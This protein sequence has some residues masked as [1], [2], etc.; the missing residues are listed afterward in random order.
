LNVKRVLTPAEGNPLYPLVAD[1]ETLTTDGRRQARVNACRQWMLPISAYPYNSIE[2]KAEARVASLRFFDLWYL[3]P[4]PEIEFDPMFYDDEPMR[5]PDLHWDIVRQWATSDANIAIAPRGSAKS[6]LVKK[7][8]ALLLLSRPV[9]SITY[10]T[11]TNENATNMGLTL[12]MQFRDNPRIRDDWDPEFPGGEIVPKR[13]ES[14]YSTNYLMLRN[15]S[16]IRCVSAEGKLRGSRPRRFRLDDPEYD[17]KASTSM[18][19]VR[20]NMRQ[21]LFNVVLPMVMRPGCGCDWL[22][23]FV[24]RRHFAWHALQT[25]VDAH[26]QRR[27]VEPRFDGWSRY[28]VKAAY[29]GANGEL[30]SCWPEMWPANDEERRLKARPECKTLEEIREKVGSSV[31][32][33]EYM[34]MPGTAEDQFFG[35]L[36][37]DKHGYQIT[38]ADDALEE[39]PR[40]SNARIQW[41]DSKGVPRGLRM[42]DFL[43]ESRLFITTDNSWTTGKDSDYKV[44]TLMA[45]T[46][47]Q[48][49][50]VLDLW[51]KQCHEQE[52]IK[53]TLRMASR[54]RCPTVH[55]ETIKQGIVLYNTLDSIVRQ[56][57]MDIYNVSFMPSIKK[58]NPGVAEKTAKIATLQPRFEYGRIK[59]P[60]HMR[61]RMPWSMLF[62]QI[63]GFNPEVLDGGL[64]NDDVIDTVAMSTLILRGRLRVS[65][66]APEERKTPLEQ[67]KAGNYTDE[68]GHFNAHAVDWMKV[69]AADILE[70]LNAGS[71]P[72]ETHD[73]RV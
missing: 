56:R 48:D 57:Q 68:H 44:A 49:L 23:T 13:G 35:N 26:G 58:F 32:L 50:F 29:E 66:H 34:A 55:V 16:Y 19:Q 36:S 12:K 42:A 51:A 59:F 53:A 22:A 31:F 7:D 14:T 6:T 39:S 17:A 69:P 5:T 45:I 38:D 8:N 2:M 25:Y 46:K 61:N 11:S 41:V 65:G 30:I 60:L 20:D 4:N 37:D 52:L 43:A 3:W 1:Y 72:S 71:R 73:S 10:A 67:L 18:A 28:V 24:S 64:K 40:L 62:D 15:G 63:E 33:G 70:I 54:W 47:D 9:N 27:A 21:F